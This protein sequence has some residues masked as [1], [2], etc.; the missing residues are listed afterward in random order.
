MSRNSLLLS[1]RGFRADEQNSPVIVL[2]NRVWKA[3]FNADP[4]ILGKSITLS[5]HPYT[6]VGVAPPY[7]RGIDL[8]LD[9]QFWVP[10]GNIDP[11]LPNTAHFDRRNYHWIAVA[12][13]LKPGVSQSEAS[14]ELNL[15]AQRFAQAHLDPDKNLGFHFE[16]A[17]SL[18]P[19]D[20]SASF[21]S[22]PRS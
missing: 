8:I 15:L 22:S 5:G 14:A 9:T 21:F 1:A 4:N 17:G 13:R 10:I 20:K 7:F 18:P 11:L 3:R 19:R 12:A 16:Q 6:V 2:G